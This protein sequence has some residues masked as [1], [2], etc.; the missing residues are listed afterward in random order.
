MNTCELCGSETESTKLR[1]VGESTIMQLCKDCRKK[2]LNEDED[3][4]IS[5]SKLSEFLMEEQSRLIKNIEE[6]ITNFNTT[7]LYELVGSYRT[8][9]N[10][11]WELELKKFDFDED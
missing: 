4:K 6:H 2:F 1:K 11:Q 8:I 3:I 10:I 9:M 7:G 5:K